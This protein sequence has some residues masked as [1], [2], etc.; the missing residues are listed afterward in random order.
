[1][2][3][4]TFFIHRRSETTLMISF[5]YRSGFPCTP[6]GVGDWGNAETEDV[7]RILIV[8]GGIAGL[9]T[10][11]CELFH[12]WPACFGRQYWSS[13][14]IGQPGGCHGRMECGKGA[15]SGA[16]ARADRDAPHLGIDP[17]LRSPGSG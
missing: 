2:L 17:R 4:A 13:C 3:C 9:R 15:G 6:G 5:V 16:P 11:L 7:Q 14:K 10:L 1:M 12:I 8:G